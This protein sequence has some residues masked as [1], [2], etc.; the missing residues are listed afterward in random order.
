[1]KNAP[2]IYERM[3]DSC[4]FGQTPLGGQFLNYDLPSLF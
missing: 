1:M 3:Y 2:V 4:I